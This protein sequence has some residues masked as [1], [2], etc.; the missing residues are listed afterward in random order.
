MQQE[1]SSSERFDEQNSDAEASL[2]DYSQAQLI[3]DP[4]KKQ[5][6]ESNSLL[7]TSLPTVLPEG[8]EISLLIIIVDPPININLPTLPVNTSIFFVRN[9]SPKTNASPSRSLKIKDL[10]PYD[11]MKDLDK[12]QP[13]ITIKRLL[14][15]A[16][17]C[18][19]SLSTSM[20]CRRSRL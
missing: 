9:Q 3:T 6:V 11:I 1:G 7:A 19:C 2:L 10:R 5:T 8:L 16:P 17:R 20:I 14:A 13:T 12:I 15:I 18:S 4:N